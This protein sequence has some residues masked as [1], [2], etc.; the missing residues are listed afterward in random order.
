MSE[1]QFAWRAALVVRSVSQRAHECVALLLPLLVWRTY[2]ATLFTGL[3]GAAVAAPIGWAS[4]LG[5]R[6]RPR[7]V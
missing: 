1:G 7:R 5:I 6:R 2:A 4:L 3:A